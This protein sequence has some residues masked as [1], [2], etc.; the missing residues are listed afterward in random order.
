MI[1]VCNLRKN[2]HSKKFFQGFT[3]NITFNFQCA[4]HTEYTIVYVQFCRILSDMMVRT[5]TEKQQI[6]VLLKVELIF[7]Q[8]CWAELES[9]RK[10]NCCVNA[11]FDVYKH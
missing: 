7:R 1:S 6:C 3:K 8:K 10:A 11:L 2:Q 5:T 9:F 4:S